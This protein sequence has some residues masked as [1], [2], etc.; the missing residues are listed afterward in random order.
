MTDPRSFGIDRRQ[1]SRDSLFYPLS[2]S[3]LCS[4]RFG[5]FNHY[6]GHVK[7]GGVMNE[8]MPSFMRWAIN[9]SE[10]AIDRW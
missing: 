2:E 1:G 5:H 6:I 3:I 9:D 4:S 8:F 10:P 7:S